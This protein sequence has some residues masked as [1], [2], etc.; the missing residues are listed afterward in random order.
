MTLITANRTYRQ[1]RPAAAE[2]EPVLREPSPVAEESSTP[3]IAVAVTPATEP[4]AV[5][6]PADAVEG[7]GKGAGE[8]AVGSNGNGL[9]AAAAKAYRRHSRQPQEDRLILEYLPLVHKIV[10]QVTSYLQPPLSREDL[11]SAGTIGLVKA[12]R[13]YDPSRQAEFGT[14]AYIRIRGAII[15][16]LRGWSFAPP[17]LKKQFDQAQQ[18]LQDMLRESGH[19][20]SDEALADQLGVTTDKMYRMFEN[21]RARHFLSIHGLSDESPALGESLAAPHQEPGGDLERRELAQKLAEAIGRLPDKQ[22]QVMLLYYTRQLTMKQAAEALDVTESRVSQL[23]A[24]AL[25]RLSTQLKAW[26]EKNA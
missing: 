2:V 20:P 24:A 11:V 1:R 17:S 3:E 15:D 8:V 18:V 10:G 21:V 9:G 13:D 26:N 19:M 16:E 22:R 12:A 25:F 14:Y 6:A 4:E 5:S 7:E 23:H